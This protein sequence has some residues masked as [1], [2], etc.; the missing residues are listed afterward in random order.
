MIDI[1]KAFDFPINIEISEDGSIYEIIIGDKKPKIE[2][3]KESP[4]PVVKIGICGHGGLGDD[5]IRLNF[6]LH[7]IPVFKKKYGN[8]LITFYGRQEYSIF[9]SINFIDRWVFNKKSNLTAMANICSSENDLSFIVRYTVTILQKGEEFVEK[10]DLGINSGNSIY[11]NLESGLGEFAF[12]KNS[13][14][15]KK[16]L[17]QSSRQIS[18]YKKLYFSLFF[19]CPFVIVSNGTDGIFPQKQTKRMSPQFINNVLSLFHKR[20]IKT[21]QIGHKTT[22][23][24]EPLVSPK[25]GINLIGKTKLNEVLFLIEKSIGVVACEGGVAHISSLLEKKTVV[26]FGPTDPVFWRYP[27]NLNLSP[28]LDV[29]PIM[30]CWLKSGRWHEECLGEKMRI[31]PSQNNGCSKCMNSHLSLTTIDKIEE[32]LLGE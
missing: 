13:L 9:K 27:K 6:I 31:V 16:S 7:L 21:I 25:M 11:E 24:I 32:Y 1:I 28:S 17:F 29:C 10:S 12:G 14:C 5:L 4:L 26:M 19:P 15:L 23:F 3:I 20:G 8:I 2:T 30:P 18:L 22:E